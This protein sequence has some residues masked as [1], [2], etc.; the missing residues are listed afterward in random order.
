ME[1]SRNNIDKHCI[2]HSS[3]FG[4]LS[5]MI[6]LLAPL[7][8]AKTF[9]TCYDEQSRPTWVSKVKAAACTSITT[10]PFITTPPLPSESYATN[11]QYEAHGG[12][13][14][15]QLGNNYW[16]SVDYN[17]RQQPAT[18]RLGNSSTTGEYWQQAYSYIHATAPA[19]TN[20]G[21]IKKITQSFGSTSLSTYYGY[22]GVNRLCNAA[23][24]VTDF[25]GV[26]PTAYTGTWQQRYDYDARG[27][28]NSITSTLPPSVQSATTFDANNRITDAG[29]GYDN[30]GNLIAMPGVTVPDKFFFDAED[31]Q[32]TLCPATTATCPDAT[33]TGNRTIYAYDA[34]GKRVQKQSVVNGA[35]RYIYD[36]LGR[37][38][39]EDGALTSVYNGTTY[40]THDHLGSTRVVSNAAGVL[41][42]HDYMPFGEDISI[43]SG[44]PRFGVVGYGPDVVRLKFSGKERDSGTGLDYFGARYFS[45]AQGR[46]TSPDWSESSQPVPYADFSDPQTL[47]LYGYVRNN[48]MNRTDPDGHC[49]TNVACWNQAGQFV[50]TKGDTLRVGAGAAIVTVTGLAAKYGEKAFEYVRANA[51]D[52]G[53]PD[54]VG[55]GPPNTFMSESTGEKQAETVKEG[56]REAMRDQGIPT[57]QQPDSQVSTEGGRQSV[58]TVPKPGGGTEKK[59]VTVN[60]N[61]QSHPGQTHV[62]AGNAKPNGQT[63][64]LGRLRVVNDKT[65]VNIK[66]KTEP[67]PQ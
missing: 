50:I 17:S 40:L 4:I 14:Q 54:M 57:S 3:A 16:E 60:H 38:A 8:H 9:T 35:T 67:E 18:M 45:G 49:G 47:N 23:E 58:Y 61:D 55:Y 5:C 44:N 42:R 36:G 48:P 34:E 20:N 13:R 66:P 39:V 30:R 11:V 2:R 33:P 63:D 25:T 1:R 59:V 56:K 62:E 64:S 43:A 41:E 28:R 21:N 32:V 6:A 26:C 52:L 65:K 51:G 46:F 31:R 15:L 12:V 10:P 19:I 27:N 53:T 37:L 22:D 7:V 29:F 24:N